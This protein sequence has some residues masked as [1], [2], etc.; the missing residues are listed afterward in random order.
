MQI[1]IPKTS[2][3]QAL[4]ILAR[5]FPT[6]VSF[7]ISMIAEMSGFLEEQKIVQRFQCLP[8]FWSI[9]RSETKLFETLNQSLTKLAKQWF[10]VTNN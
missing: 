5:R 8:N 2:Q 10:P 3:H 4:E 6:D 1:V 7:I 9:S